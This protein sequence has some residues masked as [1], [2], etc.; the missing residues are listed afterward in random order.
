MRSRLPFSLT[1]QTR[2]AQLRGDSS[3][4]RAPLCPRQPRKEGQ[5]QG[6]SRCFRS[7]SRGGGAQGN[8][9][10]APPATTPPGETRREKFVLANLSSSHKR[11][12]SPIASGARTSARGK[13]PTHRHQ[14]DTAEG[15]RGAGGSRVGLGTGT[16]A[17]GFPRA[18]AGARSRSRY[19]A[20]ALPA[21]L[22]LGGLRPRRGGRRAGAE[23]AGGGAALPASR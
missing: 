6:Q 5:H 22:L 21:G 1:N 12:S 7:C 13:R 2:K 17:G 20:L 23:G 18:G 11:L 8:P 15:T 9:F 4:Q 10:V 14:S 3:S 16:A 19:L